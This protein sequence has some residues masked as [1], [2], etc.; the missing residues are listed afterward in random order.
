MVELPLPGTKK[1]MEAWM[2]Q[3]RAGLLDLLTF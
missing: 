3:I 1:A 2:E